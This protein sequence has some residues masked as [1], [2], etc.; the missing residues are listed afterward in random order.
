MS[1]LIVVTGPPGAGKSTVARFLGDSLP[2]A[3]LVRGDDFFAFVSRGWI[4]PWLPEAQEQNDVVIEAA[5]AAK[6]R[7]VTGGYTVVYDG[8]VGPWF[9]PAFTAATG[10][11]AVHYA[12]LLPPLEECLHRVATRSGHGFTDARA[13]QRM[14]QDFAEAPVEARH[15]IRDAGGPAD[16]AGEVF[17]RFSRGDLLHP[18]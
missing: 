5:A 7:F 13:A 16:V 14:H 6:G 4:E 9:L 11:P 3:A 18:R 12:V 2:R 8:V 15:I 1:E 17:R 10:L